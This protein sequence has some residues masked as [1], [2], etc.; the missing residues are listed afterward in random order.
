[1]HGL[2]EFM[3]R[4]GHLKV[5]SNVAAE[6][7]SARHRVERQ[8][9]E[10]FTS[11]RE[12]P[13]RQLAQVAQYLEF[14][15]FCEVEGEHTKS[16]RSRYRYP[17]LIV[18]KTPSGKFVSSKTGAPIEVWW[19]DLC[20]SDPRSRSMVGSV[21]ASGKSGSK[22]GLSHVFDWAESVGLLSTSGQPTPMARLLAKLNGKTRGLEWLEN[23]YVPALDKILLGLVLITSDLDVFSRF[24]VRL[25]A[26]SFPIKK[27]SAARLFA[28]T[29]TDLVEEAD[30]ASY[31]GPRP[32]FHIGDLMRDLRKSARRNDAELGDTAIS[33]HRAAS[34]LET[35]VDLGF[36]AKEDGSASHKY[37][38]VYYET[39]LLAEVARSIE[40]ATDPEDWI[41]DRLIE[42]VL[43]HPTVDQPLE[44]D[45]LEALLPPILQALRVASTA[46][47][48]DAVAI[49]VVQLAAEEGV[50]L[51][52]R[53]GRRTVEDLAKQHP[54]IA[55]LARGSRGERAEFITID[56][57][58]FS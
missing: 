24:I 50:F 6:V 27:R 7:G 5:V 40:E 18:G 34:R 14:K 19:Q 9:A 52:L 38:Y 46:L 37:E 44:V 28:S 45:R 13:P 23:P 21:T 29:V 22:T 57:R 26:G 15:R 12:V 47:P 36:L 1:M 42:A 33:W 55:R 17:D 43:G 53:A 16:E 2:D 11:F 41:E 25:A 4:T 3:L 30:H 58:R 10:V 49:G 31:L 51:S 35:Y 48:I 32:R 8:A 39:P 54:D 56:P 20:L